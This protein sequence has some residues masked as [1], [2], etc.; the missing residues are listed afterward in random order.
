MF[1]FWVVICVSDIVW[2]W[3]YVFFFNYKVIGWFCLGLLLIRDDNVKFNDIF[4]KIIVVE[5]EFLDFWYKI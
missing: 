2:F 5:I 4:F 1:L 3:N